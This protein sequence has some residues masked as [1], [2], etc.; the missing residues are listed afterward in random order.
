MPLFDSVVG[1]FLR[2]KIQF[3]GFS[4]TLAAVCLQMMVV[5]K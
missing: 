5:M 4:E 3:G 1:T 2:S